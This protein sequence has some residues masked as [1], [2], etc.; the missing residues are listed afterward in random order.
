MKSYLARSRYN[1]HHATKPEQV[2]FGHIFD[3]YI[4]NL[5]EVKKILICL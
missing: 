5:L 3:F 2:D 4:D 1:S